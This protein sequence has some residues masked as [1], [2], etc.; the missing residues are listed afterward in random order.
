[1]EWWKR[2][3]EFG[4][5][6][7]FGHPQNTSRAIRG[8]DMASMIKYAETE[9]SWTLT[10]C[11]TEGQAPLVMSLGNRPVTVGRGTDSDMCVPASSVSKRHAEIVPG[12]EDLVLK[13]LGSTNGTY[14]NG[15][16]IEQAN[17]R[18]GDI[19]QFANSV[20]RVG[21]A[22][23]DQQRATIREGAIP[24]ANSLLHFDL[25]MTEEAVVPNYQLI[26]DLQT[27]AP[28][29][30]EMLARSSLAG[31]ETPNLMFNAAASLNQETELSELLRTAGV[32][33]AQSS[34]IPGNLFL[35]THPHEVVTPRLIRSL[36]ELRA[37]FPEHPL[38]I[39]IHEASVTDRNGM[40]HLRAVL[41][42]LKIQLAYDDF[43][44]GQARLDELA[45]VPPNYLK[46]DIKLI[47]DI[48]LASECRRDLIHSLVQ[49]ALKMGVVPLAEGVETGA[50]AATCR[51]LGFT[52]AQGYWFGHPTPAAKLM[53]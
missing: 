43:G 45:D 21:V 47:R 16:R 26:V 12:P 18:E 33:V 2:N 39:E 20:F 19:I 36:C 42:E 48:N 28:F 34:Q 46:F 44:A 49:L 41:D 8:R 29:G 11:R 24:W 25:L 37:A 23:Q 22:R 1:M 35:N 38:T 15:Q 9:I 52:L 6:D 31:L 32:R 51:E 27:G 17:V 30:H 4:P 5:A 13:D 50:E 53:W 40:R 7:H 10:E 3:R 14:V